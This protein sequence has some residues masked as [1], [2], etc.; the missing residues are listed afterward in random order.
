MEKKSLINDIGSA[1]LPSCALPESF[2]LAQTYKTQGGSYSCVSPGIIH[3]V[4]KIKDGDKIK[5]KVRETIVEGVVT[6][7]NDRVYLCQNVLSG[8]G[9]NDKKGFIYNY[10]LSREKVIVNNEEREWS[11]LDYIFKDGE[12]FKC[13]ED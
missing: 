8:A 13:V 2:K 5:I 6:I 1:Q 3:G 12:I 7:Q 9:C 4:I 11:H 10:V